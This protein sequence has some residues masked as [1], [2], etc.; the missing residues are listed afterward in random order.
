MTTLDR[1]TPS[2]SATGRK[3]LLLMIPLNLLMVPWVWI[4]RFV[5]GVYGWFA[6]ILLPVALVVAIALLVTTIMAFTQ[7]QRPRSLSGPEVFW[8]WATWAGLFAFGAFLP[9]FGDTE[10]SYQSALTRLF[11]Q[12]D[13][14]MNVSYTLAFGGAIL[15]VVAWVGLL[16]SLTHGHRRETPAS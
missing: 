2:L 6:L 16:I 1:S 3:T 14:L 9:D 8:Q 10:E 15:A 5:F 12:S 13:A 11:G 4:G 7:K